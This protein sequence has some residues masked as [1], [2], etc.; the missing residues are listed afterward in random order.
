[1]TLTLI[2]VGLCYMALLFWLASWGDKKTVLAK[3]I[4]HHPFVYS[5]ALGIYCTSWTYYGA[6]GTATNSGWSFLPILLGPALLFMFGHRFLHKLVLVSKKQNITTIADF[7]SARYGKRQLT[8][9]LVTLIALLATI[10]YL[11]LIHI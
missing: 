8:A 7:I 11:S 9:I 5:L 2:L 3:K 4:S 6:V 1:M 10:P